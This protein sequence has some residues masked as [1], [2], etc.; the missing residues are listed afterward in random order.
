MWKKKEKPEIDSKSINNSYIF[1][2]T[3]F[4]YFPPL[5]KDKIILKYINFNYIWFSLLF[6][7]IKSNL[8]KSSFQK[9]FLGIKFSLNVLFI[10]LLLKLR[11]YQT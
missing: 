7:I 8:R 4:T 10:Y 2:Q 1:F 11:M 3:H 9:Y 5:Y 6:F